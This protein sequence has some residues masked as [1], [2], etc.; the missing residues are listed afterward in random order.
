MRP[1]AP[2]VLIALAAMLIACVPGSD[3]TANGGLA[4]TS[5][6]VTSIG[7]QDIDPEARPTM[8][9]DPGG[10]VTGSTGCNQYTG[11][12]HTE[13]DR[14]AVGQVSSTLMGCD[15]QR[16]QVEAVFL[17]A[18]DGAATWRLTET[19]QLEIGGTSAMVAAP[20]IA[21]RLDGPELLTFVRG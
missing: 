20:G 3:D 7:G 16:G 18:L 1:R 19:G 21:A 5:W 4:F 13:G 15:G 10:T 9:F 14:I 17:R 8:T 11:R 2:L 6:T 12:F